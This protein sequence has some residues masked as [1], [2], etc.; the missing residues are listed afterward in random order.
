MSD[1][2]KGLIDGSELKKLEEEHKKVLEELK[3]EV[4]SVEGVH[5]IVNGVVKQQQ[6]RWEPKEWRPEYQMVVTLSL[7]NFSGAQIAEIMQEK[8][9]YSITVPHVYNILHCDKAKAILAQ[10]TNKIVEVT[11]QTV[12]AMLEETEKLASKRVLQLLKDDDIYMKNPFAVVD[13]AVKVLEGR[14]KLKREGSGFQQNNQ[15]NLFFANLPDSVQKRI[16]RGLDRVALVEELHGPAKD[17]G[18]DREGKE[19]SGTDG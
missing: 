4:D 17:T 7:M 3:E 18:N 15:A 5:G 10:A 14:G 8:Y 13:R 1:F 19:R 16:D 2:M 6:E 11:Q 12:E 9:N